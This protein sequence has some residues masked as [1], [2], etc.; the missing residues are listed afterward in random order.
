[1]AAPTADLSKLLPAGGH[2]PRS[3]SAVG[4]PGE[5]RDD[6]WRSGQLTPTHGSG[7]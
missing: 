4:L 2:L 5:L 6:T 7:R 3:G 1:M